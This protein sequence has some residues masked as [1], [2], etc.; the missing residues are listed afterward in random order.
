MGTT[1]RSLVY[2]ESLEEA[3]GWI[4]A[5]LSELEHWVPLINNY[6]PTSEISR[7]NQCIEQT[8]KVSDG[9]WE[10]LLEA[11]RWWQLSQ[12]A[13]DTTYGTLFQLWR[14]ARKNKQP[15][16]ESDVRD[17]L[18]K[19]GWDKVTLKNQSVTISRPGVLLDLSGLATGF[20]IDKAIRK[21]TSVGAKSFLVDIGGDIYLGAPPPENLGGWKITI[22]GLKKDSL[23]IEQVQLSNCAITTSGDRNQALE[24]QGRRFSHLMDPRTGEPMQFPQSASVIAKTTLDADAGATSMAILG[25]SISDAQFHSL[26][27]SRCIYLYSDPYQSLP[28]KLRSGVVPS[29]D[30]ASE[31]ASA[32]IGSSAKSV[33]YRSFENP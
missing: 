21:M 1:L 31:Q 23:P 13:F 7:L 15:P 14:N 32:E 26:P 30:T 3:Q 9:L 18:A 11:K 17:A 12:G 4:D 16:T 19:T 25:T 28:S 22:A 33:R 29:H 8:V 27:I 6:D 5:G 24:F 2:A 10:A 20:L